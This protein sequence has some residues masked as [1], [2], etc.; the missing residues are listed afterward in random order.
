MLMLMF[1]FF[2][3]GGHEFFTPSGDTKV[4][5]KRLGRSRARELGR[6]ALQR[7]RSNER[8]KSGSRSQHGNMAL[9]RTQPRFGAP[10]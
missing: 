5:G 6:Q 7:N 9:A 1:M 4:R 2:I 3:A 8:V 10:E